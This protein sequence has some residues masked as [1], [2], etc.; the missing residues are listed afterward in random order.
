MTI[1]IGITTQVIGKI[2]MTFDEWFEANRDELE[3]LLRNDQYELI[4]KAWLAG[5]EAGLDEM[6][7]FARKL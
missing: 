3:K 2:T 1:V 4:Y 6:G 5:Y 7:K